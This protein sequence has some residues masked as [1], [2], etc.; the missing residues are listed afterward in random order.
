MAEQAT[1]NATKRELRG[2]SASKRLRREGIVPAV[3]YGSKQ[4]AYMIQ[5]KESTFADVFRKQTSENFLVNLEIEGAD[6]KTK[7]AFVQDIQRNPLTGGFVHVDFRAVLDDE[8]ISATVP[9]DL[10][11]E[12]EGVKAG[13]LLEQ[14]LHSLEVQCKPADLPSHIEHD[15]NSLE[16]GESVK[17]GELDL[18][19]GVSTKMDSDVLVALVAKSRVS[20]SDDAAE[21]VEGEGEGEEGAEGAAEGEEGAS[22][23]D[24]DES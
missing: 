19:E 6:E 23:E 3:V 18:P 22:Q 16:V 2:T 9:I 21:G 15:I 24:G 13:G 17:V 1:L 20:V 5:V 11:G 8:I 12:S 4:R 14:L 7:L 10:I